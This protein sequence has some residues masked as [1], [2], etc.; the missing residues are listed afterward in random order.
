MAKRDP[1]HEALMRQA[2][3]RRRMLGLAAAVPL[4]GAALLSAC[5][6]DDDS[7][8]GDT[9]AA[10]AAATSAVATTAAAGSSV[11]ESAGAPASSAP[12]DERFDGVTI[13]VTTRPN[14]D[15]EVQ[16]FKE[17]ITSW[18]SRTGGKVN[19]TLVPFEEI[20]V[21]WAG[22]LAAEDDSVDVLYGLE[23]LVGQYG[24]QLYTDLTD[25]IDTSDFVPAAL[26]A[27]SVDGRLYG[28]PAH[29]EMA[30]FI[31]NKEYFEAAGLNPDAPPKTWAE[32]YAAAP[33]LNADGHTANATTLLF[34]AENLM[35][36]AVF[37]NSTDT[38]LLSEDLMKVNFENDEGLLAFQT[39]SDGISSK[40]FDPSL[41]NSAGELYDTGK[42]FN[43]GE[44]AS[45][46]NYVELWGA[47][48][49]PAQSK[50]SDVVGTS[51]MP[52]CK[53]GKTGSVNGFE[54][55]GV[56]KFSKNPDAALSFIN[57]LTG[58]AAQKTMTLARRYPSSRLS[59]LAD[60]EVEA[61]LTVAP[62]LIEQGQSP[63]RRPG[64]PYYSQMEEEF[65]KVLTKLS[66]GSVSAEDAMTEAA[67]NV[68]RVIDEYYA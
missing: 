59:V 54:C 5:G 20:A 29:S 1:L 6:D 52:G 49:D 3:T 24:P 33:Q 68:Q 61:A 56:N 2:M 4:G 31:Y 50:V 8:G 62:L 11:A 64:T 42:V 18:E 26:Q 39:W 27:N 48:V 67:T 43:N 9:S 37:L 28:V 55:F 7:D 34:P 51:V 15:H 14:L 13:Q 58:T 16:G 47:A 17:A 41:L 21:K 22:Y 46:I 60:D 12:A 19:F 65:A 36:F 44:T 40:F 35:F 53:E 66:Q 25:K 38:T 57:E 45:M 23:Q 30:F 32:L 10:P 63:S